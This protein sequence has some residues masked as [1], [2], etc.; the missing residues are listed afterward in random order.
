M[1]Q[2]KLCE[3]HP[4]KVHPTKEYAKVMVFSYSI[5]HVAYKNS[6]KHV[7]FIN[8]EVKSRGNKLTKTRK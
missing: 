1:A 3:M 5:I 4:E 2:N 8:H 6:L 7:E